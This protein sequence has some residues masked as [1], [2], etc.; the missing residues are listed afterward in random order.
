MTN[1]T[2]DHAYNAFAA[3]FQQPPLPQEPE[4]Q[5]EQQE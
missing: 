1:V 4:Q 2:A 3:A 5:Q